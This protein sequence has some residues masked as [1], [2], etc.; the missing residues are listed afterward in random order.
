[1]KVLF[2]SSEVW[3]LI[4]TGGLGDVSYSLP[5]A[6]H[7]QGIDVRIVLPAYQ[8]V[9]KQVT[10]MHV[11]GWMSLSLAGTTRT[12]RVVEAS[13][14]KFSMPIWLID[15]QDLFDRA[16]NP[17]VHE[18]GHD[19]VDNAERFVLFSLAVARL[20]MDDL[21][22]G[23]KPDVV[24]SNDWQTGMVPVFLDDEIERPRR[25]FTIHNMAYG[26]Y[27]SQGEF[28]R[29]QLAS[30]W[31]SSEGVEFYGN[32]SMLKAGLIYSDVITTVSPTYAE[33]IC[34]PA[35]AYGM[36]G[37]LSSRRY[38]LKGILNGIDSDVWN[39][40]TDTFLPCHYSA[41]RRNPGKMCNKQ[42]LLESYGINV[43]QEMLE[44]PLL[45]MVSRLVEQK[46]VDM[47]IQAIPELLKSS[48]AN[49]VLIGKGNPHFEA[50]LLQLSELHPERVMIDIG[51]SEEKAHLLEAGCD[52]F[53]MPSRF[54]P[55]G[56]N[57]LY[58]LRYGSIPIVHRTG[59]LADTVVDV[60]F[61]GASSHQTDKLTG[62]LFSEST[63][64]VFDL[65]ATT[66]LV[67]TIE[68]AL[69]LFSNKKYWNQLLRT[70]M[71]QDFGWSKSAKKY[72]KLYRN[73]L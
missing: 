17:Y 42:A 57:Q 21:G 63:G 64:F 46:G 4:K 67:K 7:Q 32:F 61:E 38:K 39:P 27:F 69:L 2:A 54:E 25:I 34:T 19:W 30:K 48:N 15:C 45:G 24:H 36:E 50:Q 55:C 9:L 12:V 60:Q 53:L 52:I 49:F 56:L 40:S 26:G 37:V 66:E 11:L 20:G 73:E 13:H 6:L 28:N 62:R 51:Y 70:A 8:D 18:E 14:E 44:A 1:M 31:W 71:Q 3:P 58:S 65:P 5:H 43:S 29:L 47:V 10:S 35:F 59:G 72:I 23:W 22:T 68:R 41:T 16:G 33:E